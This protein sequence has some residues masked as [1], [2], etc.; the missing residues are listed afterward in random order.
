MEETKICVKCGEGK[1]ST[2]EYFHKKSSEAD[3]LA[4]QC[5]ICFNEYDKQ[6]YRNNPELVQRKKERN[7]K[8]KENH[9]EEIKEYRRTHN[10][11]EKNRQRAKIYYANNKDKILKR[12]K[13]HCHEYQQ[14]NPERIQKRK[15]WE[16]Q[17]YQEHKEHKYQVHLEWNHKNK[18][19]IALYRQ[20]RKAHKKEVQNTLTLEQWMQVIKYFDNK[21]AYCGRELPLE[22]EHF[23]PLSKGGPLTRDNIICACKRCNSSKGN[24][25]YEDWYTQ[26]P[27]Y[28]KTREKLIISYLGYM[29][30]DLS[31]QQLMLF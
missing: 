18:D 27:F 29:K 24:T 12:R 19:R 14:K 1:P 5:K 9:A 31:K 22:K 28:D 17:Y 4:K 3:G 10:N 7:K 13:G 15:E 6:R 8:Y 26:Q 25:M 23:M 16:K 11:K 30:T 2:L 21:C 20:K